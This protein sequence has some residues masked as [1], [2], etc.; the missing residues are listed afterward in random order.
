MITTQA[1]NAIPRSACRVSNARRLVP[2]PADALGLPLTT[3]PASGPGKRQIPVLRLQAT[4]LP[5]GASSGA[6]TGTGSMRQV[7]RSPTVASVR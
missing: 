7:R 2:H 4:S 3:P 5:P 1:S 6:W